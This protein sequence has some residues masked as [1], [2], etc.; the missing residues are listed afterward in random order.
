[1]KRHIHYKQI[2]PEAL[3]IHRTF[4]A[5]DGSQHIATPI[6]IQA[7]LDLNKEMPFKSA[8]EMGAGIGTISYTLLKYTGANVDLYEDNRFC[9]EELAKNLSGFERRHKILKDYSQ[10]PPQSSYD[11]F[12]VDGG[13][14]KGEDGGDMEIVQSL[15]TA[16]DDVKIC[17]I[18]GG[19]HTQRTLLRRALSRRF[20]YRLVEYDYAEVEGQVFK[21]G[22]A[23]YCQPTRSAVVRW[24]SFIYWE[25][26]EWTPIK[27][28]IVYRLRRLKKWSI[29]PKQWIL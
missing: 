12:V 10:K 13:S 9:Q 2:S 24:V 20:R 26:V 27:N 25:V 5:K 1:M 28:A 8:L 18:E 17:Y 29:I 21:G 7:L 6:T 3:E 16:L 11:L 4:S 23:I 15:A 22:L 19:R 14:G